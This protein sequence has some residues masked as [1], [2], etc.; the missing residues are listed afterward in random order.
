MGRMRDV[1]QLSFDDEGVTISRRVYGN[2][3]NGAPVAVRRV[4]WTEDRKY[5]TEQIEKELRELGYKP[6]RGNQ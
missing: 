4:S 1:I 3:M 6:S 2:G 5:P